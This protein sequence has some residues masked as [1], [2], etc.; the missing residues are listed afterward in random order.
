MTLIMS[1]PTQFVEALKKEDIKWPVKYDDG[2]PY[3]SGGEGEYWTGYFSS[4]P[5][6]KKQ[7]KD[8]SALLNAEMRL[9]SLDVLRKGVSDKEVGDIMK[10]KNDMM[11]NTSIYLHHDAITGTAKQF[12]ADD[13]NFKMNKAMEESRENY[14]KHI[15]TNL[16]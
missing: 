5:T 4:R 14:N 10:F 12:V 15:S 11:Y 16:L 6:A 13:Y 7:V 1:T 3:S 9:A 8:A 2:F